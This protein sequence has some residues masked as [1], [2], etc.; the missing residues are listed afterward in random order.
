VKYINL[1]LGI[2][3]LFFAALQYNDPDPYIWI[4]IYV[5]GASLCLLAFRGRFFKIA[6]L[7]GIVISLAYA[8][9]LF[10]DNDGVLSW[11]TEHEAES[12]IQTMKATKPW[13]E[14]SRE[15]GGLLIV[16]LALGMNYLKA[17]KK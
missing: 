15:F 3:F 12:L 4:P 9:F 17:G 5:Y 16:I 6:S 11:A 10:L 8:L 7:T 2:L 14:E 13:I 1:S